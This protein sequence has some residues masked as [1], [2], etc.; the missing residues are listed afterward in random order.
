MFKKKEFAPAFQTKTLN[1]KKLCDEESACFLRRGVFGSFLQMKILQ[2]LR[3]LLFLQSL[4]GDLHFLPLILIKRPSLTLGSYQ[5]THFENHMVT[6]KIQHDIQYETHCDYSNL[7]G[8]G[9][10]IYSLIFSV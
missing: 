1:D 8:R 10:L 9:Y 4:T 6:L 5:V 7:E 3:F 2:S